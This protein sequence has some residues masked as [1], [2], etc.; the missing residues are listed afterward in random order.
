MT[1]TRRTALLSACAAVLPFAFE[2]TEAADE[3]RIFSDGEAPKDARLG[4]FKTL[5]GDFPF[6]PPKTKDE[7][8][9]RS[10]RIREQ[11]LVA[12]GLWPMPEQ[13]ELNPKVTGTIDAGE[14]EIDRVYFASLPGHYVTGN[15]YRPKAKADA[16]PAKYPGI[17]FAHGHWSGGRLHVETEENVRAMVARGEE[18]ELERAKYF[19]QAIPATLAK[20]GFVVFQYDMVGY[21]ESRAIP[22][23]AR[24]GVPHQEG[25]ADVDCELRLQSLMGLQTWN[26]LRALDYLASRPFVDDSKLGMTGASGGGTQTFI[27]TAIDDRIKA[28][29]PA[30]MVSTGMQGGCVCENCSL[31][32]VGT[33]NVEIAALSAPRPLALPSAN[34]WTREIMTKGYPQLRQL[35]KLLGADDA[36]SAKAWL[37]LPHNYGRPSRE[38]MADWFLKHLKG[39]DEATSEPPFVPQPIDALKVFDEKNPRP[40]DELKAAELRKAIAE[41]DEEAIRRFR[42]LDLE[43]YTGL[44]RGAVRAMIAD[45]LPKEIG[46]RSGPKESKIDGA[47]MHLAVLGRTDEADAVPHA[48]IFGPKFDGSTVVVWLHPQ[49]KS[50]LLVDGKIAPAARLLIDAGHAVVAPD[51]LGTGELAIA[52]PQPI[53]AVYAGFTFGYNRTLLAN[54]V[55]DALTTIAFAKSMLKAKA[56]HLVGW[57]SFGPVAI[58][59]KA[60]AGEAIQKLAVDRHGFD[61]AKIA[62]V[63]DP[64]MLPG[65]VKYGGLD[66]FVWLCGEKESLVANADGKAPLTADAVSEFFATKAK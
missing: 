11:L 24:S 20:L 31:L 7:W 39:R 10:T 28:S 33:G 42:K 15:L 53:D 4:K 57:E 5:D 3:T 9:K 44:L 18:P 29:V 48:G 64:M 52:K 14:Y 58:L 63:D 66:A 36:V 6:V 47:T 32:R 49:G 16:K 12:T 35:Y 51:S 65:A 60:L 46:V 40:K 26:S 13:T 27:L 25:F 30:V 22:H 54:R 56:I 17:L 21:A 61:F 55:H 59:A 62:K 8:T 41:R 50:S 1:I 2:R 23:I 43:E 19:M 37:K 38:M 45:E 34:D